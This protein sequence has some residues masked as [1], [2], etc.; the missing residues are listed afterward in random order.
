MTSCN[1]ENFFKFMSTAGI[2][3]EESFERFLII[4]LLQEDC[5]YTVNTIYL[6]LS[7]YVLSNFKFK[8]FQ[9]YLIRNTRTKVSNEIGYLTPGCLCLI[10]FD[11]ADKLLTIKT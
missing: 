9:R 8:M 3:P 1:W 11:V 6:H 10:Q 4:G 5:K 7:I 2:L